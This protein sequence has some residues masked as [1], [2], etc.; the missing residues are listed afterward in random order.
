MAMRFTKDLRS[1]SG[2]DLKILDSGRVSTEKAL[3]LFWEGVAQSPKSSSKNAW[4]T[5]TDWDKLVFR[6]D[7]SK[8]MIV[9]TLE[10]E[11]DP[12]AREILLHAISRWVQC[13]PGQCAPSVS[14]F[15]KAWM[16]K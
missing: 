8:K 1:S 2:T 7:Q 9:Y 5:L 15:V 11:D 12:V 10:W 3:L 4:V 6:L 13:H 14:D 16:R